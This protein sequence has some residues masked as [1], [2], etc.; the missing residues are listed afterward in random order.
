MCSKTFFRSSMNFKTPLPESVESWSQ[1]IYQLLRPH[2]QQCKNSASCEHL[3]D[4]KTLKGA[5]NRRVQEIGSRSDCCETNYAVSLCAHSTKLPIVCFLVWTFEFGSWVVIDHIS[6]VFV[7]LASVYCLLCSSMYLKRRV[8]ESGGGEGRVKSTSATNKR[9]SSSYIYVCN[10]DAWSYWRLAFIFRLLRMVA[11]VTTTVCVIWDV[12]AMNGEV[13]MHQH[14]T[15]NRFA[16]AS[17][18]CSAITA[19][20]QS[21]TFGNDWWCN[22]R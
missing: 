5:V 8:F 11:M 7:T 16:C 18:S 1:H 4:A 15:P 12:M 6:G 10:K 17:N 3:E 2:S 20:V 21:D 19:S 9:V 13:I 22:T 14:S